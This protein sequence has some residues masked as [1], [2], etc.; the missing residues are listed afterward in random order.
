MPFLHFGIHSFFTQAWSLLFIHT[1]IPVVIVACHSKIRMSFPLLFSYNLKEKSK[2]EKGEKEKRKEQIQKRTHSFLRREEISPP[3]TPWRQKNKWKAKGCCL[4]YVSFLYFFP[5]TSMK[6]YEW[7]WNPRAGA[8]GAEEDDDD[9]DADDDKVDNDD[10]ALTAFHSARMP[11][12]LRIERYRSRR[13]CR[14]TPSRTCDEEEDGDDDAEV[15][16]KDDDGGA[17]GIERKRGYASDDEGQ[18]NSGE[19]RRRVPVSLSLLYRLYAPPPSTSF[20]RC[21]RER[22]HSMVA[23]STLTSFSLPSIVAVAAAAAAV[24]MAVL[25]VRPFAAWKAAAAGGTSESGVGCCWCCPCRCRW[26]DRDDDSFSS[27]SSR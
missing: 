23:S 11:L 4:Y 12:P 6:R 3:S 19:E 26:G 21:R 1:L 20:S 13:P 5:S 14:R 16:G 27:S 15:D 24:V 25:D 10:E 18:A 9:A 17:G 8:P 7:R 2:R 22:N